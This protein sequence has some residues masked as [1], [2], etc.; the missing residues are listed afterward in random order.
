MFSYEG[1]YID[2]RHLETMHKR[3]MA[4]RAGAGHR[5]S[6]AAQDPQNVLTGTAGLTSIP[7]PSPLSSRLALENGT[8]RIFIMQCFFVDVFF[9]PSLHR[10]KFSV[11]RE[12]G[13][14]PNHLT[15]LLSGL[16]P[17]GQCCWGMKDSAGLLWRSRVVFQLLQKLSLR[18]DLHSDQ[19]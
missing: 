9:A 4:P 5:H 17:P 16:R 3:F 14:T 10:G 1:K 18:S 8:I 11:P 6:N 19:K 7:A 13:T 15:T 2:C 12:A